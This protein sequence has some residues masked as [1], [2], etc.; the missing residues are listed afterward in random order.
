MQETWHTP[1]NIGHIA[2]GVFNAFKLSNTPEAHLQHAT[3][4]EASNLM[5]TFACQHATSTRHCPFSLLRC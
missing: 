4:K 2:T 1:L 3:E 5:E